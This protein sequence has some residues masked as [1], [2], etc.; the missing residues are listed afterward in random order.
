VLPGVAVVGPAPPMREVANPPDPGGPTQPWLIALF[1]AA[2]LAVAW[3][4]GAGWSRAALGPGIA[5]V[6]AGPAFGLGALVLAGV[7]VDRAG[8]RLTGAVPIVT[9]ALVAAG[10]FVAARRAGDGGGPD[11]GG[12]DGGGVE[13]EEVG[14]V[15]G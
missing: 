15:E 1:A 13:A 6:A 14:V 2:A 5:S 8:I 7:A 3:L 10:G 11:G 12:R 4:A 9:S